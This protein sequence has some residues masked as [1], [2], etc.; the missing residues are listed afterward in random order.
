MTAEPG[1]KDASAASA[2]ETLGP[3]VHDPYI[4]AWAEEHLP[5]MRRSVSEKRTLR[6]SLGLASWSVWSPTSA[7]TCSKHG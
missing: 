3:W 1:A 5:K 4:L 2:D 6:W 7:A